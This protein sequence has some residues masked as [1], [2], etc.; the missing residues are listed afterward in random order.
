MQYFSR[1][2][3]HLSITVAAQGRKKGKTAKF[4]SRRAL[5]WCRN[6]D[7]TN[8]HSF[9]MCIITRRAQHTLLFLFY[10]FSGTLQRA[11]CD[12]FSH[13][14]NNT[15]RV[16]STKKVVDTLCTV[17]CPAG[18]CCACASLTGGRDGKSSPGRRRTLGDGAKRGAPLG[19][20]VDTFEAGLEVQQ[21]RAVDVHWLRMA[22]GRAS[23]NQHPI[24]MVP[25]TTA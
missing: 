11:V 22:S 17:S 15:K 2:P 9:A 13:A 5:R 12:P 10:S 18:I 21:A 25:D 19:R 6:V 3:C 24:R 4:A 8:S 23:S 14:K 1:Y 16:S 7:T 20:F